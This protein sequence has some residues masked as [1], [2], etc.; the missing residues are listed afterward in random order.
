MHELEVGENLLQIAEADLVRP[1]AQGVVGVAVHLHEDA[2]NA[3]A[4]GG[5]G[6]N[7]SQLAIA[8]RGAAEAARALHGVGGVENDGA[9]VLL[10]PVHAAHVDDEVVVAEGG[11]ALAEHVLRAAEGIHLLADVLAVP[12]GEKLAF[13][14]VDGAPGFGADLQQVALAAEEGRHLEQVD[15]LGRTRGLRFGVHV[16]HHRDLQLL[17]DFGEDAAAGL[18][19][20]AA[21]ALDAG[22]VGFVVRGFEDEG[23]LE[24]IADLFDAAG[25][26]PRE[27]FAFKR[28]GT[29]QVERAGAAD[30]NVLNEKAH[31]CEGRGVRSGGSQCV[32]W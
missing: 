31:G 32:R 9:A 25:H 22:A 16:G 21:E 14:D 8:A 2:V 28:T 29:K 20:E 24:P 12:R 30:F 15:V 19:T 7:G 10:H 3:H 6:Q 1:V 13:F 5:I 17:A 26:L 27:L 4:H 23:K 11:A 18:E